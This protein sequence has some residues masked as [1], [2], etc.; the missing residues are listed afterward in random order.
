MLESKLVL[1]DVSKCL[2]YCSE[3]WGDDTPMNA[4][5]YA[6][7]KKAL[8]LGRMMKSGFRSE[9]IEADCRYRHTAFKVD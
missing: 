7:A 1:S 3:E 4:A 8:D 9:E 2:R 5:I 6:Q